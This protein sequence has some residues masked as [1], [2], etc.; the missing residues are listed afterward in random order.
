MSFEVSQDD[1]TKILS[2]PITSAGFMTPDAFD[3]SKKLSAEPQV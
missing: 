3:S 2:D 1:N